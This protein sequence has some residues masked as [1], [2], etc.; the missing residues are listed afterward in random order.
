MTLGTATIQHIVPGCKLFNALGLSSSLTSY[1]PWKIRAFMVWRD[2]IMIISDWSTGS[3]AEPPFSPRLDRSKTK[4]AYEPRKVPR[5]ATV[6]LS[7]Q[8]TVYVK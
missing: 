1:G 8:N 7:E 5:Y 2:P 4:V 6:T 3:K